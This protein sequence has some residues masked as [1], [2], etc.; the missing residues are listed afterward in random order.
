MG[1]N[2]LHSAV[3]GGRH[4][5]QGSRLFSA[6]AVV[7]QGNELKGPVHENNTVMRVFSELLPAFVCRI[8]ACH[9]SWPRRSPCPP[10]SARPRTCCAPDRRTAGVEL[11]FA[12]G[13]KAARLQRTQR[14]SRHPVPVS[15]HGCALLP[16]SIR[17][18]HAH[19]CHEVAKLRTQPVPSLV[20]VGEE[21]AARSPSCACR[22]ID[23]INVLSDVSASA[24]LVPGHRRGWR[25]RR[26]H[27]N[28]SHVTDCG[29]NNAHIKHLAFGGDAGD[30][31]RFF[32]FCHTITKRTYMCDQNHA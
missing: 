31:G 9:C 16:A 19:I 12:T 26:L 4:Q 23:Y 10:S 28:L 13:T 21:V 5:F 2:S 18:E 29:G 14:C 24:T 1:C 8:Q 15:E 25:A 22:L 17:G 3:P 20:L 6:S 32:F 7:L 11:T 30:A 27:R